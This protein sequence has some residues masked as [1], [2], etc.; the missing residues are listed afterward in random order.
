MSLDLQYDCMPIIHLGIKVP[1][2]LVYIR[3]MADLG[4]LVS[5]L[6]RNHVA[7]C[8]FELMGG[9]SLYQVLSFYQAW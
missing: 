4:T 6:G 7:K 5:V 8:G 9:G 2:Y 3:Q 1:R